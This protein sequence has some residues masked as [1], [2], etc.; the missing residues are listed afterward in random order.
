MANLESILERLL[1]P[2]STVIRQATQDLQSIYKDPSV[3]PVLCQILTSS[4][5]PQIRQFAAVVLRKRLVK[6]WKR[7]DAPTKESI[8]TALIQILV[9]ERTHIVLNSV[10]HLAAMLVLDALMDS[11]ALELQSQFVSIFALL[12]DALHDSSSYVVQFYA[13]RCLT[14]MA[15]YVREEECHRFVELI[16]NVV[17]VIKALVLRDEDKACE[18]MELFDELVECEVDITSHVSLLI[19]FFLELATNT[20]LGNSIRVKGLALVSWLITIRKKHG[21]LPI[22][23]E[24]VLNI[25]A[26]P[27]GE[28]GDDPVESQSPISVAA[29]VLDVLALNLPP[30][31]IFT[32]VLQMVVPW[33]DSDNEFQRTAAMIA[34]AVMVEG[35]SEHIRNNCVPQLLQFTYKAVTDRSH[36]VRNASLFAIGQFSE[37]LQPE[38]SQYSADLLPILFQFVDHALVSS[39]EENSYLTKIFY[40]LETFCE[41]L[42]PGLTPYLPVL[43]DK[44]FMAVAPSA[45]IHTREL[46]TSAIG[47]VANAC[48]EGLL[49]F[50]PRIIQ[51]L[52]EYLTMSYNKSYSVLQSQ[53]VDTLGV[54]ARTIGTENFA[55]ISNESIAL[56]LNLLHVDDPDLRRSVYGLFASLSYVLGDKMG[57]YLNDIVP[58]M[59]NSLSS[60]EG[61]S[62]VYAAS[63][64]SFLDFSEAEEGEGEEEEEALEDN[65]GVQGYSVENAFLEEKED[66]CNA[67]AEIAENV[68]AAFLPYLDDCFRE[69]NVLSEHSAVGIRKASISTLGVFCQV[70]YQ[71]CSL[72]DRANLDVLVNTTLLSM[73][74]VVRTD[75]D[76]T[77]VIATLETLESLLKFLKGVSF[78]ME[79]NPL[80]SLSVSIQDVLEL[81][82]QCQGVSEGNESGEEGY[83]AEYDSVLVECA[84]CVIGPLAAVAGGEVFLPFLRSLLPQLLRRLSP[85]STVADKSFAIGTLAEDNLHPKLSQ[86]SDVTTLIYSRHCSALP[87]QDCPRD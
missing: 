26:T 31:K 16:P 28:E 69:V 18:A 40:A 34:M 36:I 3:V 73:A 87:R 77:V 67:L 14:V 56:A 46:G 72:E 32:P 65:D 9:Q 7:L 39:H 61:V 71:L 49:P 54:L 25:M 45:S 59:I 51:L 44:L 62:T 55:P 78:I 27:T 52:R 85:S 6:M 35:C 63:N 80:D 19:R 33:L 82:A 2:D 11:A 13:I 50:F 74:A 47:A 58:Q 24:A 22:I 10:A 68:G 4:H 37:Y 15:E 41:Q 75:T 66:A 20:S 30:E 42:G 83:M 17:T 48:Q 76:R 23:L 60:E 70:W 84:G 43:M 8:K 38:I 53:A 64:M 12:L 86:K 81:K 29:Q 79:R 57:S 1:V 5:N 21:L